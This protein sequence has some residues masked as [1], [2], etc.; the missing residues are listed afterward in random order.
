MQEAVGVGGTPVHDPQLG[1]G[2]RAVSLQGKSS[3]FSPSLP[4]FWTL[5]KSYWTG[6]DDT[7]PMEGSLSGCVTGQDTTRH[8]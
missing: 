7:V 8:L 4:V 2:S 6:L 3:V 5:P 1:E